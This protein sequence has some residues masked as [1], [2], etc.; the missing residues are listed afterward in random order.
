M[1][2][3]SHFDGTNVVTDK[4]TRRLR[5]LLTLPQIGKC[6]QSQNRCESNLVSVYLNPSLLVSQ[7]KKSQ[8]ST[9]YLVFELQ[10]FSIHVIKF[11]AQDYELYSLINACQW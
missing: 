4:T 8:P 11:D 3:L 7:I 1:I 9:L 2:V 6:Q 5:R 10:M